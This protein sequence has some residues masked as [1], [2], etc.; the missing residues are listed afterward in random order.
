MSTWQ[1]DAGR[2][3][4]AA[5]QL[6]SEGG[7]HAEVPRQ[8]RRCD[9]RDGLRFRP[10]PLGGPPPAR[11]PHATEFLQRQGVPCKQLKGFVLQQAERLRTHSHAVAEPSGPAP[12]VPRILRAQGR[13]G[14]GSRHADDITGGSSVSSRRSSRAP[15]F[16]SPTVAAGQRSAPRGGSASSC[17]STSSRSCSAS[18]HGRPSRGAESDGAAARPIRILR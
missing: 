10:R 4:I 11:L 2:C 8:A 7:C 17:T 1:P 12:V 5:R 15:A 18:L 13:A 9:D 14:P 3:I 16:G 6:R